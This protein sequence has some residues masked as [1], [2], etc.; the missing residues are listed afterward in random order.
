MYKIAIC[1]KSNSGKNTLSKL[2]RKEIKNNLGLN[3]PRTKYIAF[4]DPIKEMALIMFPQ[5]PRKFFFGSSE[6]RAEI[7]PGAFKDGNPLTVRQLLLDL[8]T[9]IGRSYKKTV[10]LDVFNHRIQKAQKNKM[11]LIVVTD[12]RFI[13]EF[14]HL[15]KIGFYNIKLLRDSH[16]KINHSSETDQDS[17][18]DEEFDYIIHNNGTLDD[19]KNEVSKIVSGLN[20]K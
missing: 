18:K 1:G 15:K 12:V 7:I 10:W 16:L 19:L 2:L 3:I 13:N 11:G 6:Y 17:I 14:E 9:E 5:I 4:A 8:G 20:H